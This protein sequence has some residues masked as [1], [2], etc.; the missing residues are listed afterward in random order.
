MTM[1]FKTKGCEFNAHPLHISNFKKIIILGISSLFIF[2]S[3]WNYSGRL[4]ALNFF[5]NLSNR[6]KIKKMLLDQRGLEPG[7][8]HLLGE[9]H[10]HYT[11][12]TPDGK[13]C[14]RN[15]YQY[16]LVNILAIFTS[17]VLLPYWLLYGNRGTSMGVAWFTY[18]TCYI[19]YGHMWLR[20][21]QR[22][23]WLYFPFMWYLQEM[24]KNHKVAYSTYFCW[25]LFQ[26]FLSDT[27]YGY[28]KCSQSG[29]RIL[30]N[31]WYS[32]F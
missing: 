18:P 28:H 27:L 10:N 14:Y 29:C 7:T 16:N 11:M 12:G 13:V 9:R 5:L 22:H 31:V 25:C 4:Y 2:T 21:L 3:I 19:V 24:N 32:G 26:T 6:Q 1:D 17:N 30:A 8:S 15:Q 20:P 23:T